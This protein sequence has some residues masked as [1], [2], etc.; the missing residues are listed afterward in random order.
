MG[1]LE[2]EKIMP[3]HIPRKVTS[4]DPG[5]LLGTLNLGQVTGQKQ[6]LAAHVG[7]LFVILETLLEGI[8]WT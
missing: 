6:P 1:C 5:L 3:W 8:A 2:R 7:R 4:Y